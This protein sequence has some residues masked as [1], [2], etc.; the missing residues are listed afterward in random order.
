MP[1]QCGKRFCMVGDNEQLPPV[2]Q[3]VAASYHGARV[4]LTR[5]LCDVGCWPR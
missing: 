5:A 1:P 2:V 4:L 3:K